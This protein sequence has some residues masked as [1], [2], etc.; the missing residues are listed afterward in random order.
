MLEA[1]PCDKGSAEDEVK[2]PF[3]GDGEDDEDWRESQKQDDE[4]VEIM[5]V[6]LEAMEKR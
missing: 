5:A 6:G 1:D 4:P 2:E 3:V